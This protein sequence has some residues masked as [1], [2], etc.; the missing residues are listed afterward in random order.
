MDDNIYKK[1]TQIKLWVFT[2]KYI[3]ND[4]PNIYVFWSKKKMIGPI[5]ENIIATFLSIGLKEKHIPLILKEQKQKKNIF[6]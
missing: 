5:Y 3:D 6:L 1:Y 2:S 4:R